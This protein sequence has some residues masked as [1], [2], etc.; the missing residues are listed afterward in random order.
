MAETIKDWDAFEFVAPPL[1]GAET[2]KGLRRGRPVSAGELLARHPDPRK[3]DIHAPVNG[4]V[5]DINEFEI[6]IRRD[7]QAVGEPPPPRRLAGL[8]PAALAAALKSLGL[9]QP[10]VHP[11]DPL[12]FS[13]L[14]P[15]PGPRYAVA[16][17]DEHRETMLAGAEAAGHLW[18]GHRVIWAVDRAGA[19]PP[20]ADT[21]EVV[22]TF[23]RGLPALIKKQVTGRKDPE[24][25]GVLGARELYFLG[26]IWRTGLPLTRLVLTLGGANYFVPLGGRVIDLL[27]FANLVPG[28]NDAVVRDG[29]ETG[30]TL[31]RL[32]RGLNQSASALHLLRGAAA[33]E[34]F[35]PCRHCGACSYI[36]PAKLR[37]DR[38]A[39]L[40]PA[41]WLNEKYDALLEGCYRCGVCAAVCPARRPLKAMVRLLTGRKAAPNNGME[42]AESSSRPEQPLHDAAAHRPSRA[43]KK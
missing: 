29:L 9:D 13:T 38:A 22:G 15:E 18:P 7:D 19:P 5:A 11:G 27:T 26:R 33:G 36:C 37:V 3:G 35:Q 4:L 40:D 34:A 24:A 1:N 6:V 20:E 25:S 32:T 21:S 41:E 31:C 30:T 14:N 23:P 42:T 39:R 16:L 12:I 8:T 17:F 43:R 2:V 10:L 28:P